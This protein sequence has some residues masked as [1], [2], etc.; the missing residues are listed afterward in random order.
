[1]AKIV[2]FPPT[3]RRSGRRLA[4]LASSRANY[5]PQSLKWLR[6]QSLG[7]KMQ[8]LALLQPRSLRIFEGV[9]DDMLRRL[10]HRQ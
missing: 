3:R 4:K 8:L 5:A 6:V 2:P 9:V 10:L 1:M 7:D